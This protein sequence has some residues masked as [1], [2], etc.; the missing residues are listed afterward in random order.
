[1]IM[2]T[3]CPADSL[4]D[5]RQYTL[6]VGDGARAPGKLVFHAADDSL[7]TER[8]FVST[9]GVLL[10]NH[11]EILFD[12]EGV[13]AALN[14]WFPRAG[15]TIGR[16]DPPAAPPGTLRVSADVIPGVSMRCNEFDDPWP[17]VYD[18]GNGWIRISRAVDRV[19]GEF[20]EFM[21]GAVAHV[22]GGELVGLWLRPSG[23]SG[24]A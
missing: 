23:I 5:M 2:V 4:S 24:R 15:W 16:L 20:V 18:P 12:D 14:G 11:V 8:E 6:S 3:S 7:L 21:E 22:Q 9:P 10:V 1:M 19:G 17:V 13:V